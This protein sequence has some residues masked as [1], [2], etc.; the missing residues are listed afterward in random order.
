MFRKQAG[1][2]LGLSIQVEGEKA[3]KR[4]VLVQDVLESQNK[5]S[6]PNSMGS[7]GARGSY[8]TKVTDLQFRRRVVAD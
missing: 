2:L 6:A 1:G 3:E 5:E 7:G 8:C 4:L